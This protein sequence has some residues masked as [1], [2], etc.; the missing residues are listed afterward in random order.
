MAEVRTDHRAIAS[1]L[2]CTHWTVKAH[3]YSVCTAAQRSCAHATL[4]V[5]ARLHSQFALHS[6][7]ASDVVAD[8]KLAPLPDE[9]WVEVLGWLRRSELGE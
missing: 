5:G 6:G 1:V 3:T 9:L 7:L 2:E 8:P 4:L